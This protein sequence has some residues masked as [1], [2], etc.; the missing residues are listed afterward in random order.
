MGVE[1]RQ[2]LQRERGGLAHLGPHRHASAAQRQRPHV[3]DPLQRPTGSRRVARLDR[4]LE[5]RLLRAGRLRDLDPRLLDVD[6][7]QHHPVRPER[8]RL[9]LH[10]GAFR[11]QNL[12]AFGIAQLDAVDADVEESADVQIRH[13]QVAG[14]RVSRLVRNEAPELLGAGAGLQPDEPRHDRQH[15]ETEH[16]EERDPQH[17]AGL[18]P[19]RLQLARRRAHRLV[20]RFWRVLGHCPAILATRRPLRI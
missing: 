10:A 2:I 18:A 20:D 15:H 6:F 7:G 13:A 1:D 5:R 17:A 11:G 8:E 14:D 4:A 19:T 12:V 9:E 16:R 3:D